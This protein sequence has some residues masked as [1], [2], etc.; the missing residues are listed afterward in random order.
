MRWI[1]L[2]ALPAL[3]LVLASGAARA[4]DPLKSPECGAAIAQLQAARAGDA[5]DVAAL[6]DSAARLC[7]GASQ[8]TRRG[9]RWAQPPIAVPAPVIEVPPSP[10]PSRSPQGYVPLPPPLP[11]ERPATITSCDPNGCWTSEGARLPRQGPILIGPNGPC[12]VQ[13]GSAFCR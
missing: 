1:A 10:P 6:R 5:A 7:L 3:L 4:Q 8:P 2:P 11:I 13:A 12:T 9:N